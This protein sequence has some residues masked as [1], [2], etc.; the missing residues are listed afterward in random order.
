ML[1]N[2]YAT[3]LGDNSELKLKPPAVCLNKKIRVLEL[4]PVPD[5]LGKKNVYQSCIRDTTFR[6][7]TISAITSGNCR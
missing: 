4:F 7:L 1:I 5:L 3:K 2:N 6:L